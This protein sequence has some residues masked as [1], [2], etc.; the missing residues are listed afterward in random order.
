V[1]VTRFDPARPL[2]IVPG[3]VWGTRGGP[4]RLR[5]VLDTGAALSTIEPGVL[6]AIGY[7]PRQ[8]EAIT[9]LRSA[10][11][12]E[13]GYVLRVLRFSALGHELKDFR[14]HAH[15]LPDG[16]EIDGLLGLNFLRQFDYEIRSSEGRIFT[17]RAG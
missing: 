11:A 2:I 8:G 12:E 14:V 17:K 5:L 13:P 16:F 9:T 10:V 3:Y 1:K 7:S 6:D 15:D 4:H